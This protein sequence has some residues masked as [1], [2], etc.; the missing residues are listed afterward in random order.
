MGR[1][2]AST[3]AVAGLVAAGL[4]VAAAVGQV[5]QQQDGRLFDANPQIGGTRFNYSRAADPIMSG[6]PFATGNVRFGQSLRIASPINNPFS[7]SAPLGSSSLSDFVRDS[8]SIADAPYTQ[9]GLGGVAYYDPSR[10]APTGAYLQGGLGAPTFAS[11]FGLQPAERGA[12]NPGLVQFGPARRPEAGLAGYDATQSATLGPLSVQPSLGSPKPAA[13]A[14]DPQN[15]AARVG[16]QFALDSLRT[17]D[18]TQLRPL[19]PSFAGLGPEETAAPSAVPGTSVL[20]LRLNEAQPV[21]ARITS[22]LTA[23]AA[24]EPV[25]TGPLSSVLTGDARAVL[26]P[27]ADSPIRA[28]WSGALTQADGGAGALPGREPP[29]AGLSREQLAAMSLLPGSDVFTDMQMA[30]AM[31]DNPQAP[32]LEDLRT[33]APGGQGSPP[34]ADPGEFL[35]LLAQR[36]LASFAGR[37]QSPLNDLMRS[38]EDLV[39][40]QRYRDAARQYERAERLEPRNPLPLLGKGHALLAEGQ[41]DSAAV[42]ILRGLERYPDLTRF[43]MD[44]EAL[45]GGGEI[46]DI[47]RAEITARLQANEDANLRFLLGYIEYHSGQKELGLANLQRAADEAPIGSFMREYPALLRGERT[48]PPPRLD[49]ASVDAPQTEKP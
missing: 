7:F 8:F 10:L 38:A 11:T 34:V 36:P 23:P 19:D 15:W 21:D 40:Q 43:S 14:D 22:V 2:M 12:N 48:P 39:V 30:I 5:P 6:N 24:H 41:Y 46:V 17:S 45:L 33:L 31:S 25:V 44:I 49:E 28:P 20:D 29:A 13:S 35:A 37:A 1:S 47:R 3:I 26:M 32:W 42:S 27:T 16:P 18:P 4:G 9:R